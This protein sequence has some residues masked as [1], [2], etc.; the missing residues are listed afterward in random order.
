VANLGF[1]FLTAAIQHS[2]DWLCHKD[3]ATKASSGKS[4]EKAVK[5]E[6]DGERSGGGYRSG[7]RG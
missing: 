7:D 6:A 2:Q 1:S 3:G 4:F 5:R